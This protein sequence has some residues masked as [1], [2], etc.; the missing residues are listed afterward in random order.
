M[1]RSIR[2]DPDDYDYEGRRNFRKDRKRAR[3]EEKEARRA[4]K[5]QKDVDYIHR[6]RDEE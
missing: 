2:F 1:A 3:R 5:R 6:D 4:A